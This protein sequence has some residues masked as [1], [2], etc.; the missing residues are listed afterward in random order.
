MSDAML[1]YLHENIAVS[2][3]AEITAHRK[4]WVHN[5]F[6]N[7]GSIFDY[8]TGR[9]SETADEVGD[10]RWQKIAQNRVEGSPS[11]FWN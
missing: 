4:Q 9:H 5:L 6:N 8:V 7:C 3:V 2:T 11:W 1:A 10:D